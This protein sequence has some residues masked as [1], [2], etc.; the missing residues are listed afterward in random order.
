MAHLHDSRGDQGE[1]N[2]D[3]N[4]EATRPLLLAL[5]GAPAVEAAAQTAAEEHVVQAGALIFLSILLA[6]AT[7]PIVINLLVLLLDLS[8]I[9]I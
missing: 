9:H 7:T 2:E 8:L 3:R 5:D 4:S 6:A 1:N